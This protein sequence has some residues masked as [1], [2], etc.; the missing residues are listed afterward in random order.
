[1]NKTE[2]DKL[3]N[4]RVLLGVAAMR[5]ENEEG[6]DVE[7]INEQLDAIDGLLGDY[8]PQKGLDHDI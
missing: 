7:D 6:V 3:Y 1:M 2:H 5:V 4:I 8:V